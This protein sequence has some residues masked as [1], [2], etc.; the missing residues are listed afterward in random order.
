M[1]G[2]RQLRTTP[3]FLLDQSR[4]R[5]DG[6]LAASNSME[7]MPSV[8]ESHLPAILQFRFLKIHQMPQFEALYLFFSVPILGPGLI[9][10]LVPFVPFDRGRKV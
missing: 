5:P 7:Q 2:A 1:P 6:S 9:C 10:S 4:C 8:L 3:N